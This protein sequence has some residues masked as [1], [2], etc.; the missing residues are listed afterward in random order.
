MPQAD[1]HFGD[2]LALHI[3]EG[4]VARYACNVIGV[5][6]SKSSQLRELAGFEKGLSEGSEVHVN[7]IFRDAHES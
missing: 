3:T 2:A 6:N 7:G 1:E 5:R 4:G